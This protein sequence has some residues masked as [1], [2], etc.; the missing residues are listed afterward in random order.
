MLWLLRE[1]YIKQED[2]TLGY[3]HTAILE[4]ASGSRLVG[5]GGFGWD[6][7]IGEGEMNNVMTS[8][9]GISQG[10]G[11]FLGRFSEGNFGGKFCKTISLLKLVSK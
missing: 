11:F 3:I 6:R 8:E 7:E 10:V 4:G 5:E 2:S 9:R 1:W